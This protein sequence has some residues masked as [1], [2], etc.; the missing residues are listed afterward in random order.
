[1]P[2]QYKDFFDNGDESPPSKFKT[3]KSKPKATKIRRTVTIVS[4]GRKKKTSWSPDRRQSSMPVTRKKTDKEVRP[5]ET[6]SP[7]AANSA[8]HKTSSSDDLLV[9]VSPF[10]QQSKS[11]QRQ[12]EDKKPEDARKISTPE[13]GGKLRRSLA[14]FTISE[15]SSCDYESSR[16]Q[17]D[18]ASRKESQRRRGTA[19]FQQAP[20]QRQSS[21]AFT[22]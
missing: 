6:E 9:H 21:G 7:L 10:H 4:K 3:N 15:E 20:V 5:A 14:E 22:F 11:A 12:P 1:M 16:G 19:Q 18:G 2:D 8:K 13:L 17:T